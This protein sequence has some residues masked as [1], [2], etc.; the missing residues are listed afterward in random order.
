M[1]FIFHKYHGTGND[2]ILIDNR[3]GNFQPPDNNYQAL[4]AHLC[5]RQL[6][7]GAD[8]LILLSKSQRADFRMTYFNSDGREGSLCG[9]GSRCLAA[10]ACQSGLVADK[11]MT[12]EAADGRHTATILSQTGSLFE[13]KVELLPVSPPEK[14]AKNR[15]FVNTGSPHLV[16]F[17]DDLD[18]LDVVSEGRR[19]RHTPPWYH[20]GIN[21]DFVSTKAHNKLSVRTYERGVE[22][23]TLSCGTGVTAAAIAAWV[24]DPGEASMQYHIT[25]QGGSLEVSF[26]PAKKNQPNFTD[27]YLTGPAQFVY[28]G[29]MVY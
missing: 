13:V 26:S 10:F 18:N 5:H 22:N 24:N 4:I 9:N 11:H 28:K 17:V 6:G 7:I 12:F 20:E 19:L 15:Y 21:V 23:E 2:F 8:G 16:V 3:N 1:H 14:T 29:E 25:T 27:I